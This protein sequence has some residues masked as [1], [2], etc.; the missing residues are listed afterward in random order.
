[1]WSDSYILLL[2]FVYNIGGFFFFKQEKSV[3]F[4]NCD[5]GNLCQLFQVTDYF[6]VEQLNETVHILTVGM[7]YLLGNVGGGST[8]A[9]GALRGLSYYTNYTEGK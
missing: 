1:M 8:S 7:S 9:A 5:L 6:N 2:H 4:V 3:S